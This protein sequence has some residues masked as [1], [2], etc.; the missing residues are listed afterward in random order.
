MVSNRCRRGRR[1]P[2]TPSAAIFSCRWCRECPPPPRG[3]RAHV[4]AHSSAVEHLPYKQAVT[5]S[6]PVAPTA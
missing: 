5:G 3:S 1:R 2:E 4:R 6:I